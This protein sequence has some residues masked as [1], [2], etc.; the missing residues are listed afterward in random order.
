MTALGGITLVKKRNDVIHADT[1]IH[2][3]SLPRMPNAAPRGPSQGAET[4][5]RLVP[6]SLPCV[7]PTPGRYDG[8]ILVFRLIHDEWSFDHRRRASRSPAA[9]FVE[10]AVDIVEI[11]DRLEREDAI[12]VPALTAEYRA[13]LLVEARTT[14]F[15]DAR[16]VVR[17]RRAPRPPADGGA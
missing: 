17:P 11:L 2:G 5:P 12:A 15:R 13:W 14:R 9:R 4:D 1:G 3:L 10:P 7:S 8:C 16:P 6:V